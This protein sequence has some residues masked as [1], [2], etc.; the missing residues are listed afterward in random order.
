MTRTIDQCVKEAYAALREAENIANKT[1]ESF[2]F[3]VSYGMG[4]TYYPKKPMTR[5]EALELLKSKAPLTEEQ[6]SDIAVALEDDEDNYG[7]TGWVS[8]SSMC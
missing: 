6:R 3:D 5:N 4:G 1:G 8:S 7:E 2:D